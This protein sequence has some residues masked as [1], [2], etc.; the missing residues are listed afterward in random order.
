MKITRSFPEPPCRRSLLLLALLCATASVGSAAELGV[1]NCTTAEDCPDGSYCNELGTC[2]TMGFCAGVADCSYPA[3]QY[4]M[5][6]CIGTTFCEQG[7]CGI[8]CGGKDRNEVIAC[9]ETNADI[10]CGDK[11]YCS[12][13]GTC[14]EIGSCSILDDCFVASNVGYPVA[15]CIGNMECKIQGKCAMD[16]SGGSDAFG[17]C[18][19]SDECFSANG[20][21]CSS[22]GV[23]RESGSC[24]YV[25]DCENTN[26]SYME[27]QCV[28]TTTCEDYMCGKICDG[29]DIPPPPPTEPASTTGCATSNDCVNGVEYCATGGTCLQIG[30]C[31]I[32][33]DCFEEANGPFSVVMCAGT[34]ECQEGTCAMNCEGAEPPSE[35]VVS[36][37]PP[38]TTLCMGNS[39]CDSQTEYCAQ[40]T[41]LENGRCSSDSD[42]KNPNHMFA[43]IKCFGYQYCDADGFCDRECGVECPGGQ[44]PAQCNTT[45]CDT[46]ELSSCADAVSCS[47]DYCNDCS[48]DFYDEAGFVIEECID[49]D[50]ANATAVQAPSISCT[51][52]EDCLSLVPRQ[53]AEDGSDHFCGQGT[54]MEMG[55]CLSDSDCIN[56]ANMFQDKMC[57]GYLTCDDDTGMCDR[58]CGETC[59]NG[60]RSVQCFADPCSVTDA[61]PGSVSCQST[62][63]DGACNAIY[64]DAAGQLL[65]DCESAGAETGG[66]DRNGSV[67]KGV[68]TPAA[69]G[70]T[71][72]ALESSGFATFDTLVLLPLSSVLLTASL[73]LVF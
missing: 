35:P 49:M 56:P 71:A 62:T 24:T 22:D 9:D 20:E 42:C 4:S 46:T 25:E 51:R 60:S 12:S 36:A 2:L 44:R 61:C 55:S 43:D 34:L 65:E 19:S 70:T 1:L 32:D 10:V 48:G 28:G 57:A 31:S 38:A 40:G 16:C 15:A 23:C 26:N 27:A 63:C 52:D 21:Y 54:C 72:A 13:D 33:G 7:Q 6:E 30:L 5:I 45:K 17:E 3:N 47:P 18:A 73:L 53:R 11:N 59:K 69:A 50:N 8:E 39:D 67:E 58:I 37:E 41:C 29:V 68:T 14:T 64:F 66:N